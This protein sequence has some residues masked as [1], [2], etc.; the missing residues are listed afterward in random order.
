ML[1]WFTK[2]ALCQAEVIS[3]FAKINEFVDQGGVCDIICL[4][5]ISGY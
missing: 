5:W 4:Y 2:G 3:F 1:Q